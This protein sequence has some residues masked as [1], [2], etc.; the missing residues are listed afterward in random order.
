M[1]TPSP[2]RVGVG[3][4]LYAGGQVLLG[5]RSRSVR[6]YQGK[7]DIIGGHLEADETPEATLIRELREELGVTPTVFEQ[8]A[9]FH[10]R[11]PMPEGEVSYRYHVYVITAW[12]GTPHNLSDEHDSI[13]WVHVADLAKLDLAAPEYVALFGALREVDRR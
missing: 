10:E 4:V 2:V 13:A 3:G 1:A 9:S 6:S 5:K 12:D 7:W 11:S 8:L